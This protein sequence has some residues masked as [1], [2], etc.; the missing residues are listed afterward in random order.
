ML[1]ASRRPRQVSPPWV[2]LQRVDDGPHGSARHEAIRVPL[3]GGAAA[4][5]SLPTRLVCPLPPCGRRLGRRP[6]PPAAVRPVDRGYL[7]TVPR[8]SGRVARGMP[9]VRR[10]RSEGPPCLRAGRNEGILVYQNR[11]GR[12]N[13]ITIAPRAQTRGA[14]F[15]RDFYVRGKVYVASRTS[16]WIEREEKPGRTAFPT[17]SND[18][19]K[20]EQSPPKIKKKN[21][22]VHARIS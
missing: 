1:R 20:D 10:E 8:V 16:G 2:R 6:S 11:D 4:R 7:G 5:P 15:I 19:G 18:R 9:P 13:E 12:V 21:K 3:A 22:R 14:I 17:A